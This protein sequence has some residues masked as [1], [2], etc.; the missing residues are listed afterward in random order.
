VGAEGANNRRGQDG[1]EAEELPP[2]TMRRQG[3]GN[4]QSDHTSHIAE[5]GRVTM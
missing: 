3:L 4:R 2:V 1:G 5:Q